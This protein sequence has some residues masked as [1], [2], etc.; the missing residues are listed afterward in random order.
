MKK[1]IFIFIFSISVVGCA[2]QIPI[3]PNINIKK[4]SIYRQMA[5]N[6]LL[7]KDYKNVPTSISYLDK[8]NKLQPNNA[9][10]FYLLGVS[11]MI[12]NRME[13]AYK[14]LKKSIAI[15][16]NYAD[17]HNAIGIWYGKKHKWSQALE[18]FSSVIKHAKYKYPV[19]GFY[20]RAIAYEHLHR[21]YDAVKDLKN[22]IDLGKG[23]NRNWLYHLASDYYEIGKFNRT[24]EVL[25]NIKRKDSLNNKELFLMARGFLHLRKY[26]KSRSI[27]EILIKNGNSEIKKKAL[28]YIRI[29]NA[30]G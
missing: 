9:E 12:E 28:L 26:K 29:I 14:W 11:Y 17:A 5:A 10:T 1:F 3:R 6:I 23:F 8:A 16:K 20:N 27:L 7:Y 25:N 15:N 18:Q 22:A 4:A 19:N 2:R 21:Y 24:I 30:G 13:T